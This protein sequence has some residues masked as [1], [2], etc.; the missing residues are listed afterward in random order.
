MGLIRKFLLS[1]LCITL[2]SC[3]AG[4]RTLTGIKSPV[5][6]TKS[7]VSSYWEAQQLTQQTYFFKPPSDTISLYTNMLRS[8]N[9]DILLFDHSGNQLCYAN[10][11]ACLAAQI[12]DA[13][14]NISAH[15]GPCE[16]QEF[17]LSE[18]VNRLQDS[19][20]ETAALSRE[21]EPDYYLI[22]FWSKFASNPGRLK[23]DIA[24]Y[25]TLAREAN[26]SVRPIYVNTDLLDEYGLETGG[27]LRF[28][29]LPAKAGF[30]IHFGDMP[31]KKN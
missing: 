15:F 1:I 13:R 7:T 12:S 3:S 9:S 8:F 31:Y 18:L 20:G 17:S 4:V 23:T 2:A 24:D 27:K 26:A 28:R 5:V 10:T 19:N 25:E 29:Y 14:E 6:E 21:P 16:K 22:V 11:D 30:T